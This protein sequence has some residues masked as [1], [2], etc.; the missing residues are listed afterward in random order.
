MAARYHDEAVDQSGV[1]RARRMRMMHRL[2]KLSLLTM[3]GAGSV[4]GAGQAAEPPA[5]PRFD[6]T[7]YDVTGGSLLE[8]ATVQAALAPHLGK[9]RRFA[10]VEAARQALLAAY[11]SRGYTTVQ[12]LLPEQEI[13]AGVVRLEVQETRLGKVALIGAK[14]HDLDNVRASLPGLQEGKVPN[15]E[16]LSDS[17]RLANE[18]PSKKTHLLFKA[19]AQPG[20][21]DATLR[22]EDSKPWKAYV[23]LDNTGS[24]ETGESRLAVGYQH[25][26]IGNRDHVLTLQYITSPE[27]VSDV[28]V[29]GAGY[30]IPLY[31]QG[32]AIEFF[33]GYSDV[34][35]GTIQGLFNI[36]GQGTILGARYSHNFRET[37]AYEHK[38]SVGIDYRAYT[39]NIDF[40]GAPIGNDVTVHPINLTYDGKWRGNSREAGLYATLAHNIPGGDQGS[41][42]DFNATRTGAD[43]SYALGRLG[44]NYAYSTTT[45]WQVRVALDAQFTGE[46]LVP[47]E[48]FGIG[49]QDSVR[50]FG[51]RV[52][53]G[54]RGWRA[55]MEVFTPDLG[56]KT[57]LSGANLRLSA[58]VEGGHIGRL[59]P[60]PGEDA[61][62]GIASA[63]LGLR[64]GLKDNLSI[65]LDYGHVLDG[66]GGKDPGDGRLHASVAYVF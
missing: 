21:T 27:Q 19:G 7:R 11:T 54:D 14:H 31:V 36:S 20:E 51:E 49:G 39:N 46:P 24:D 52:V 28:S 2:I 13:T 3:I 12:V 32:D 22:L 44:G 60:Q 58:F 38:L 6:V 8:I 29:V 35:S 33:A 34:D 62:A 64:F 26:N 65:R 15:T 9:D 4:V 1:N 23:S 5:E 40:F 66:G 50:G 63:G 57:G 53:L 16:V 10:D 30:H 47:G 45:D 43:A 17:L 18:N 37:R 42:A 59:K 61:E 41:D 48:Q 25:A 56:G 55:G